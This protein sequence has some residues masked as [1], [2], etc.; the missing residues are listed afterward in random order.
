MNVPGYSARPMAVMPLNGVAGAG[1]VAAMLAPM[2]MNDPALLAEP[3]SDSNRD[4][5][6]LPPPTRLRL[7]LTRSTASGT[8]VEPV[9]SAV[10]QLAPPL[11]ETRRIALEPSTLWMA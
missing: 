1:S 2:L 5:E 3:L 4:V 11:L 6:L 10:D 8:T 9:L 7:G